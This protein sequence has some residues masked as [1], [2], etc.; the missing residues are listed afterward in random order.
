MILFSILAFALFLAAVVPFA[1]LVLDLFRPVH[2][3]RRRSYAL[4]STLVTTRGVTSAARRD[5]EL[6]VR[7]RLYPGQRLSTQDAAA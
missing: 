6:R 5:L 7:R 1:L 3:A 2:L 4:P